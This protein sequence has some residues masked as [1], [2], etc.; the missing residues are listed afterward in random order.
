MH[1]VLRI[2]LYLLY[3]FRQPNMRKFAYFYSHFN[4][5]HHITGLVVQIF[6]YDGRLENHWDEFVYQ[7]FSS[8]LRYQTQVFDRFVFQRFYLLLLLLL[9]I[10]SLVMS[11]IG[12][13]GF[14]KHFLR[15][16]VPLKKPKTNRL[17]RMPQNNPKLANVSNNHVRYNLHRKTSYKA[18]S[19]K[20][21]LMTSRV[22]LVKANKR[23]SF[24]KANFVLFTRLVRNYFV[25]Y[26]HRNANYGKRR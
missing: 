8:R 6:Y 18:R 26:L 22:P 23:K 11:R 24:A 10:N 3:F 14:V 15:T 21:R 4:I 20:R 1:V 25:L 13:K 16:R 9:L 5:A 7:S 12:L 17:A 19:L 2:R